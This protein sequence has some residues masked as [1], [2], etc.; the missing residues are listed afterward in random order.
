MSCFYQDE[1]LHFGDKKN[2]TS[3]S[4]LD[5][6]VPTYLYKKSL[7]T[8]RVLAVKNRVPKCGKIFFAAK[9]NSNNEILSHLQ[10][11]G[12]GLDVVSGG[13][14]KKGIEAGISPQNMI[15]SGVGKSYEDLKFAIEN[16]IHQI[17][18][19]SLPELL[20]IKKISADLKKSPAIS[21]RFN[22]SLTVQTHKKIATGGSSNKFGILYED[23]LLMV[24]HLKEVN[25]VGLSVHVGSQ[26]FSKD[27][28]KNAFT[29]LV[30]LYHELKVIFPNLN[31]LDFGG[32]LGI[33]YDKDDEK[34]ELNLLQSYFDLV[35]ELAPNDLLELQFEPGRFLI[36]HAGVLVTS[37]EYLKRGIKKSFLILGSGMNHLMRPALYGANHRIL[38][39][40]THT[41]REKILCDI[42]GPVC[43][44][45][46]LFLTDVTLPIL[47]EG[48]L[49]AIL[50]VG[51][52]GFT[53]SSGYNSFELPF[54]MVI[55]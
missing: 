17:N 7:I 18:V 51:A 25:F 39:L 44:S 30:K 8:E 27:D 36:A 16:E 40:F 13:E 2:S 33:Y 48:E 21:I 26:L 32:G 5:L 41:E 54:E 23:L 11:L 52:Y 29:A 31:R 28:F 49:V 1:T 9:A 43:E 50:D 3:L 45:S 15:Y 22:P 38:P 53:M 55:P 24:P 37:V 12:V 19:E 4:S 20:R 46:D 35:S 34:G 10:T 47:N 42:V 6:V 14:I